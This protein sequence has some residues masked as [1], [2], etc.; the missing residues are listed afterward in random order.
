VNR[1]PIIKLLYKSKSHSLFHVPATSSPAHTLQTSRNIALLQK[2][3]LK[4]SV[5]KIL[6]ILRNPHVHHLTNNSTSIF[7]ILD[8][9]NPVHNLAFSSIKILSNI[10]FPSTS[11]SYKFSLSFSFSYQISLS[12]SLFYH[13]Y[14]KFRQCMFNCFHSDTKICFNFPQMMIANAL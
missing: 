6:R 5:K 14:Q 2:I 11:K 7:L 12:S 8:E 1:S 13:P 9:T 10:V 4:Q 3:T